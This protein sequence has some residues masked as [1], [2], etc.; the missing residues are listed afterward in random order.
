M[1]KNAFLERE[2]YTIEGVSFCICD[3]DSG[4]VL[5]RDQRKKSE[6]DL[7][8]ISRFCQWASLRLKNAS[9]KFNISV[10][11]NLDG[12]EAE[13]ENVSDTSNAHLNIR[14]TTNGEDILI[15]SVFK[16]GVMVYQYYGLYD[17][18]YVEEKKVKVK[19]LQPE[20]L[21]NWRKAGYRPMYFKGRT[22]MMLTG[23]YLENICKEK[24]KI[25]LQFVADTLKRAL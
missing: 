4:L 8:T 13:V 14:F 25:D 20:V 11:K 23:D 22:Y 15:A 21:G 2:Y 18:I 19:R 9:D 16:S 1:V 3:N 24:E 7:E 12:Y 17:W 10:K 5:S 6:M